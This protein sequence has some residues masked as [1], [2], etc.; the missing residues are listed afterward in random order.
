MV[1]KFPSV[2]VVSVIALILCDVSADVHTRFYWEPMA[3]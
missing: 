2:L 1:N 3:S